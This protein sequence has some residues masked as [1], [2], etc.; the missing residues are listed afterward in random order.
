VQLTNKSHPPSSLTLTFFPSVV[1]LVAS[2]SLEVRKLVYIYLL[3][4]SPYDPDL[5]LLSINTFQKD[6][7]SDP[8]P[9]I[10][11]MALRVLSGMRVPMLANVVVMGIKKCASDT[12]P[13]VR[14]VAALAI[15]KCYE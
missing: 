14:K 4:H 3:H 5:T 15:P 9:L 12:S 1:K 13:Y 10:R 7:S 8:N 2:P 6:L 11:A